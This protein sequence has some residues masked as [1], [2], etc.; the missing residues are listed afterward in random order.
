[1][2]Y[3]PHPNLKNLIHSRQF[4]PNLTDEERAE[5]AKEMG[6]K[7]GE[8]RR[9]KK[10]LRE[11]ARMLLDL[12]LTDEDE[13][14]QELANRGMDTTEGVAILYAQVQRARK[15]DVEAARFLRD[16]SGQ[17]PRDQ[18][19]VGGIE[20]QP[21]EVVDFT[22]LTDAQLKQM[23]M[24]AEEACT[25]PP[26]GIDTSEQIDVVTADVETSETTIDWW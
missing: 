17:K 24:D 22:K 26:C 23:I 21:L 14:K 15:G 4:D 12:E 18:L 6:R 10:V 7:S 5:A 8:T 1:M 20:D 9:R 19:E 11:H 16:T 13:L 3:E 2:A 25:I